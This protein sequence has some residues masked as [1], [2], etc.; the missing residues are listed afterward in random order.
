MIQLF[1]ILKLAKVNRLFILTAL[2]YAIE[3]CE[4][5]AHILYMYLANQKY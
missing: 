3:A 1:S 5:S 4:S 2:K